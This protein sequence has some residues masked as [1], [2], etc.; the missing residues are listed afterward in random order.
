MSFEA[1]VG[2]AKNSLNYDLQLDPLRRSNSDLASFP[3]LYPDAVQ[4][5]YVPWLQFRGGR[6]GNAGQYQTDRGPFT[7]ENQTWDVVGNLTKVWGAHTSKAG[8]YYQN[9]RKPQSI[10]YSFNGAVNFT[11]DSSNPFDTGYS[12]ANA[13]TGVFNTYTQA[14]KFSIPNYVYK[15][16]EFYAQDNWKRNRLTLDYGVRFYVLTPQWDTTEQVSNFLPNE[17]N[18][19][20]AAGLFS[21]VCLTASPCSGADRR[22]MDPA[23]LAQ[24]VAPTLANT[25]EARFIGRLTPGSDRF[26]GAFQAGQGISNTVQNGNAFR[27]SPRLGAVYDLSGTGTTIIRGGW[28]IFFD[29]PQGNMV[30]DLGG[31]APGVLSSTVQWGRLQDISGGAAASADP[32]PTLGLNPTAFDFDPPRVQQWN[33][34]VQRKLPYNLVADLAYVGSHSDHQL[35]QEQIN[36]IPLGAAFQAGNQDPTKAASATP[37]G[38]ALPNDIM[39][40]YSGYNNIRMWDYSGYSNYNAL[41]A[42]VTR[43]FDKNYMF[44]AFYVWSKSLTINNDDFTAG[45]PFSTDDATI[46]HYDYSYANFDRPHNFV[47]NAIYQTPHWK[48]GLTGIVTNDWQISG[49]YRFTSGRPYG[50]GYSI[51]GIS[52]INLT[53]LRLRRA[54]GGDLQPGERLEQRSLPTARHLVLRAAAAG[55]QGGRVVA[56]LPA[57]SGAEQRGPVALEAVRRLQGREVRV[58]GRRVQRAQPHAVHGRQRDRELREPDRPHDH[59]PAVQRGRGPREQERVRHHQRCQYPAHPAAGDARHLLTAWAGAERPALHTSSR[60]AQGLG[61]R[62]RPLLF[63]SI[64][65]SPSWPPGRP[66]WRHLSGSR[67]PVS[68]S[69]RRV[70][71]GISTLSGTRAGTQALDGSADLP[72]TIGSASSIGIAPRARDALRQVVASTNSVIRQW[73]PASCGSS[74]M[75]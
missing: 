5:D 48:E 66:P 9:S 71:S 40:P 75:L 53:G 62:A 39:R 43:R 21:P 42:G 17:F 15:N 33:L 68:P 30:F 64:L 19:A 12:Y 3:Y 8:V 22:G 45:W 18:Q 24:G 65:G 1:S 51:P 2:T 25:V 63:G 26:N 27:I 36:S 55:Q 32:Y 37:G 46:R 16:L 34:G 44:S 13:A 35:R 59:E 28:G 70:R 58:S 49:V 60:H 38:S 74:M 29:R 61:L 52:N 4:S 20:S 72:G 67:V 57:R 7:N 11:N 56:L 47:L 14:N 73:P 6:T 50:I 69:G 10:F 41:Q 54:R 23:L 31:N